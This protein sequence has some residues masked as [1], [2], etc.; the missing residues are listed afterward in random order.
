VQ[1]VKAE[2]HDLHV[3]TSVNGW[4]ND[5][6]SVAWLKQVFNRYTRVRARGKY[7]LLVLDGHSSHVTQAFIEYAHTNKILL[8]V[9]PLHA[10]HAL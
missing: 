4:S 9:F 3:G 2:K 6:L 5:A 7:R 1:R 8:L 10:T